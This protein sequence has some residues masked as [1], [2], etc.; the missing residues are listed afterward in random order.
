ME[1]TDEELRPYR[2][3]GSSSFDPLYLTQLSALTLKMARKNGREFGIGGNNKADEETMRTPRIRWASR[4]RYVNQA[5]YAVLLAMPP[6]AVGTAFRTLGVELDIFAP[7]LCSGSSRKLGKYIGEPDFMLFSYEP[8]EVVL[9][10]IKIGAADKYDFEQ[11]S[12]YMLYGALLRAA[13]IARRVE[14]LL[15]VPDPSDPKKFCADFKKWR[16]SITGGQLH[17]DPDLIPP[18]RSRGKSKKL[19]WEDRAGWIRFAE[20]L[21]RSEKYQHANSFTNEEVDELQMEKFAPNLIPA[22]VVTW[23]SLCE[24]LKAACGLPLHHIQQSIDRLE[25]LGLAIPF[26]EKEFRSAV[27]RDLRETALYG[28]ENAVVVMQRAWQQWTGNPGP[29]TVLEDLAVSIVE[30]EWDLFFEGD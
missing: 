24:A 10:E 23:P 4:E 28:Q 27:R 9:G 21:L 6:E 8:N 30:D 25:I 15:V 26:T 20:K 13:G 17:A 11:F 3:K 14:H 19:R 18:R 5:L 22:R 29:P 1:F 16:P 7:R 12:K 2:I